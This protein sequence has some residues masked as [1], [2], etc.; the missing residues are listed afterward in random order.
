MLTLITTSK[1]TAS[2]PWLATGRN[3]MV[4][5]DCPHASRVGA[6]I[7]KA[8]GNAFDATVAVSFTLAVT[9]PQS[10]G[11]GGGAFLIARFADGRIFV[12]DAR[13]TTPA[14]ASPQDYAKHPANEPPPSLY[15]HRAVGV[16]GL[17]A[18]RCQALS[19]HGTMPLPKLLTPAIKLAKEGFLIDQSYLDAVAEA[20]SAYEKY[21][22]LKES[23][24]YVWR[25]HLA[26]GRPRAVG[27]T[28]VQPQL[29][30]LLEGIAEHGPDFFYQGPV[31]RAIAD[32]MRKHHGYIT[33]ADLA[34]FQAKT[35]DPLRFTYRDFDIIA[36]PPPSSGGVALAEALQILEA[37]D[38]KNV[39]IRDPA[40]AWHYQIEAMK[41]VF[42]DRA[43]WLGDADFVAVP[44]TYLIAREYAHELAR[45]INPD[46]V[47]DLDT[48]GVVQLPDDAGTSH[49]SIAD[50]F[51]NVVVSTETVNTEFGSLAAVE[52]WGLVLNNQMDDFAATPGVPNAYGLI[53]SER[54][55]I[56]PGKR[57]LSSMT[58][59]IVLKDNEPY[60]LLG[61]SGGPRI[62]TSVLNVMLNVLDRG[63]SLE[64]AM[65]A[66]RPH[67]QWRPETVFFDAEPP[68]SLRSALQSR[69]H[70]LADRRRT[71]IVQ[72]I[73]RTNDGWIGASD[74]RKGG[75][76]TGY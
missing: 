46:D 12:Q 13:E 39:L 35:R 45:N 47:T 55:A 18:G 30:R 38:F 41:H 23:C 57:P 7:L 24:S 26:E 40:L 65:S 27:E 72:A 61:A 52:E 54:N 51:G 67:H 36:M 42:A 2:P 63:Q 59:T 64:E 25:T 68:A 37:L 10:T 50:A 53:Q 5:T 76:P 22:S 58:P 1:T 9:R 4:A 3:A 62:I 11:L 43:R 6:D 73:L 31:A 49:F 21:P 48:Y 69:G 19:L 70:Q 60:L 16:P 66:V 71:G 32:E 75:R 17:V 33:E 28:L 44:L 15:G 29:A 34:G 74:P 56:E 8:G 14:G 20:R